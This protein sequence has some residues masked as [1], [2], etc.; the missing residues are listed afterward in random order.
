MLK[1]IDQVMFAYALIHRLTPVE[2]QATRERLAAHLAGQDADE[3]AL[4]VAVMR[5]LR[6]ADR[7]TQHRRIGNSL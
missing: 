1:A 5:Y 2:V 4:A 3:N 6:E 7:D